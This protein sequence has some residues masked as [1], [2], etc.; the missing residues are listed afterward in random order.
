MNLSQFC[1]LVY[2]ATIPN[3]SLGAK[4]GKKVPRELRKSKSRHNRDDG[5]CELEINCKDDPTGTGTEEG[6]TGPVRLP[7]RG[8]RGPAGDKGAKGE[9]G[10]DGISGLPG[11]PGLSAPTRKNV[12]F[13]AGLSDNI[14]PVTKHTDILFDQVVTNEGSGYDATTGR[15]TAP[16]NGTYQFNVVISAQGRQKAAVMILK[17]GIMVATVWAESIP[18]WA[19]SSNI[20][21]LSL[22]KGDSVWLAL[23]NRA[24]HLHGY[25]YSTFSG[26]L[27]FQSAP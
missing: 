4:E 27:I 12:A 9:S 6:V 22:E 10:S 17:N 8:P 21:I 2:I 1:I 15:F 5:V 13:F 26:F 19:T 16:V 7:I 25:M 24:S 20:V 18:F 23:L 3:D 11:L 14:G